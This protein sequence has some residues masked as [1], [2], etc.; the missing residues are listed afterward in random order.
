MISE[1]L[2]RAIYAKD[3]SITH[4]NLSG[5]EINSEEFSEK[6]LPALMTNK[7]IT[8]INLS[9][10]NLGDEIA[11]R[12]K[13]FIENSDSLT[14]LDISHN[15]ISPVGAASLSI[16]LGKNKSLIEINLSHN[17]FG[18]RDAASCLGKSLKE[19]TTLKSLNISS[20]NLESGM[21]DLS[22]G[23]CEN[24]TLRKVDLSNNAGRCRDTMSYESYIR[25]L[26]DNEGL[27]EIITSDEIRYGIRVIL[28]EAL[29]S[30]RS[31]LEAAERDSEPAA[32]CGSGSSEAASSPSRAVLESQKLR[33]DIIDLDVIDILR[34]GVSSLSI[35]NNVAASRP[36]AA[37]RPTVES[38]KSEH[39][40]SADKKRGQKR[41][42]D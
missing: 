32:A 11:D 22:E 16:A 9:N 31:R 25:E 34:E 14:S 26:R 41:G 10:C 15:K 18:S 3:P 1:E 23:L 17:D 33:S 30:N 42:R 8:T 5:T 29:E 28:D 20:A 38:A 13:E 35:K 24:K 7:A 27:V 12:L 6:L 39:V 19:N 36:I 2:L 40:L 21:R 37:P 4:L